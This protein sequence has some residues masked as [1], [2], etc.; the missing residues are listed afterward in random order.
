MIGTI[1]SPPPNLVL[2][3]E[4]YFL[5]ERQDKED[6][7]DDDDKGDL[8]EVMIPPMGGIITMIPP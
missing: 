2:S 1:L 4:I 8:P 6:E 7:D 5:S 3:H